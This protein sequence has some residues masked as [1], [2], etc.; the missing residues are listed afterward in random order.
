MSFVK[1]FILK[2]LRRSQCGFNPINCTLEVLERDCAYVVPL[3]GEDH[4]F[5][6]LTPDGFHACFLHHTLDVAGRVA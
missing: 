5:V 4:L 1:L 3:H 2:K 6:D